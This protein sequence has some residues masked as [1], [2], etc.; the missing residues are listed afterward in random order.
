MEF[1]S[2]AIV[3]IK[4]L[5]LLKYG[6]KEQNKEFLLANK[7]YFRPSVLEQLLEELT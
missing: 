4:L 5:S 7:V 3:Y 2:M 6:S 1:S